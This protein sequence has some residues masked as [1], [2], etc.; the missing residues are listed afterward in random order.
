MPYSAVKQPKRHLTEH[1]AP[2]PGTQLHSLVA[3]SGA[4]RALQRPGVSA[5]PQAPTPTAP[6]QPLERRHCPPAHNRLRLW[7]LTCNP[8]CKGTC[9]SPGSPVLC[10]RTF[11]FLCLQNLYLSSLHIARTFH[12]VFVAMSF[13]G[14]QKSII[15]VNISSGLFPPAPHLMR[16]QQ[17]SA[18]PKLGE[19]KRRK[20]GERKKKH[21]REMRLRC[22][23]VAN[24]GLQYRRR[25]PSSPGSTSASTRKT[26]YT[27]TPSDVSRSLKRRRR[28]STM[29]PRSTSRPSMAC[30]P[31][32]LNLVKQ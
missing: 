29:S 5:A 27:S 16:P 9:P 25:K 21:P 7:P 32:R 1:G 31:T 10:A 30:C 12:R 13:K 4:Q 3:N 23:A 6:T 26:Q 19:A 2:R 18:P 11:G 15:R 8:A 20:R 22:D 14:F 28:S 24:L 17:K